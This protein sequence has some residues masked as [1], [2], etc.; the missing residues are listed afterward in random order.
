MDK[1]CTKCGSDD[2]TL[3]APHINKG[4]TICLRCV[5]KEIDI[6]RENLKNGKNNN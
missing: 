1:K 3:T 4:Q 5:D 6:Y 2:S